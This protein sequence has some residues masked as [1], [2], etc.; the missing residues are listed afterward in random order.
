MSG[1]PRL[2]VWA[3]VGLRLVTPP[4]GRSVFEKLGFR[5]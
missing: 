3:T 5:R 1:Q 4:L 2:P